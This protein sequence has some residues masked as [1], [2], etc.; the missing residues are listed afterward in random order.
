MDGELS[1]SSSFSNPA[2]SRFC[3]AS[4]S[5]FLLP[6]LNSSSRYCSDWNPE[7]RPSVFRNDEYSNGVSVDSTL[8]APSSSS[9]S[10]DMR[11]S[12]LND[13]SRLSRRTHSNTWSS[14]CRN[15]RI[16]SSDTW[17]TMMNNISSCSMELGCCAASS[18]SSCRYSPYDCEVVS[19]TH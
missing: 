8:Q 15:S 2:G 5:R 10:R 3:T 11:A 1:A 4:T 16:H 14:S 13:G 19:Y 17:W 6:S 12:I 7:D 9:C 18:L